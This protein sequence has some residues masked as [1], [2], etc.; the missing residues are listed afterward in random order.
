MQWPGPGNNSFS[1]FDITRTYLD[2]KF[3]PNDDISF[4]S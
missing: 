2:F 1:Q 4:A 3:T